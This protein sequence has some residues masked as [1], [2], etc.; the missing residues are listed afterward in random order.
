MLLVYNERRRARRDQPDHSG[1]Q[2]HTQVMKTD[3]LKQALDKFGFDA[4][5]G[6]ARRDERR[7]GAKSACSRSFDRARVGPAQSAA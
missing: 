7:A 4:A 2:L 5:F 6:G 3:A 1:S